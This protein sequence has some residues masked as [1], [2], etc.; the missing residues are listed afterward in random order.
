VLRRRTILAVAMVALGSA[1]LALVPRAGVARAAP[2][3]LESYRTFGVA[4]GAEFSFTFKGSLFEPLL[5]IGLPYARSGVKSEAGATANSAAGQVYPGDLIA[6]QVGDDFPGIASAAYPPGRDHV[7][8]LVPF[9]GDGPVSADAGRVRA[10]AAAD[11]A[12]GLVTTA[13]GGFANGEV[14]LLTLGASRVSSEARLTEAGVV[15][16][17]RSTVNGIELDLADGFA[18]RIEEV[19]SRAE[20]LS[21]GVEG[22]AEARLT[23][24]GV[25]VEFGGQ[26]LEAM[27]DDE[28]LH[29]SDPLQDVAGVPLDLE[30][31]VQAGLRQLGVSISTAGPIRIVDGASAESSVGGLVIGLTGEIPIVPVPQAFAQLI[32][33]VRNAL[34]GQVSDPICFQD[35]DPDAPLPLCLGI[36]FLPGPGSGMVQTLSIGNVNAIAGASLAPGGDGRDDGGDGD[37]DGFLGIPTDPGGGGPDPVPST[38][39]NGGGGNGGEPGGVQLSGLLAKMPPGVLLGFG[40]AFFLVAALVSLASPARLRRSPRS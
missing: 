2:V 21:D 5:H 34:P 37:D 12:L 7:K 28:G 9:P 24:A 22:E 15:Q 27:I 36:N 13:G 14:P 35:L 32:G 3:T 33:E 39:G 25:V 38:P 16:T 4:R 26:T 20:A 1:C 23:V 18:I 10:E 31:A 6:S 40:L 11:H 19:V 17:V 30:Q 8:D 29:L